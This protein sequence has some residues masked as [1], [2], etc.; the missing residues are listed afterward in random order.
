MYN[1]LGYGE[2]QAL[3]V[4][5]AS[6]LA[7]WAE[8]VGDHQANHAKATDHVGEEPEAEHVRPKIPNPERGSHN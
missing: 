7:S 2:Q 8:A 3:H 4:D 6:H 5:D 1:S